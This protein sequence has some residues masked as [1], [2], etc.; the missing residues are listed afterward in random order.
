[1]WLASLH[2]SQFHN[3]GAISLEKRKCD[4]L[5]HEHS[6]NLKIITMKN[7]VYSSSLHYNAMI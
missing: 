3:P 6:F 7:G 1:M 4:K 5:V 2:S